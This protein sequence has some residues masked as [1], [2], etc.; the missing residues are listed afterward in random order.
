MFHEGWVGPDGNLLLITVDGPWDLNLVGGVNAEM[1]PINEDESG[2]GHLESKAPTTLS[3]TTCRGAFA[4]ACALGGRSWLAVQGPHDVLGGGDRRDGERER[5]GQL[6][7]G[8][9]AEDGSTAGRRD[10]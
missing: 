3:G 8:C 9:H 7:E 1:P 5:K 10:R 6:L 4:P 2:P